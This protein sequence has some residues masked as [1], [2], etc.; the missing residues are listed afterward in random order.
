MDG[1]FAVFA[2][3]SPPHRLIVDRDDL[4]VDDLAVDDL[5]AD[6]LDAV[7]ARCQLIT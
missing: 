5:D 2:V 4:A 3:F 6:D 7:V 1:R